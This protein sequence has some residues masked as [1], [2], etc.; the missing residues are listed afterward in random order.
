LECVKGFTPAQ[1]K[2][3]PAPDR[4]SPAE[5]AEHVAFVEDRVY[6]RIT[7]KSLQ[8][9]ADPEKRKT[10]PHRDMKVV[11]LGNSRKPDLQ[12][13]DYVQPSS[14]WAVPDE[15]LQNVRAARSRTKDFVKTTHADLRTHY[16]DHPFFGTL[17]TYQWLLLI[18]A[19]MR[20][21]TLQ[22]EEVK[23]HPDFPKA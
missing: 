5:A 16:L 11:E 2:F 21:H 15:L 1:W 6:R 4:W 12:A 8:E 13:P 7:E 14:R 10:L 22:I 23:S 3:K 17:D 20:R 9:P 18:S 19:H